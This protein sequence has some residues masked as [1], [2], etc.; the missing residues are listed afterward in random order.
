M[1][2]LGLKT[3]TLIADC[4]GLIERAGR[5]PPDVDHLPLDDPQTY[6][7]FRAAHTAGVFQ[8]ESSG[9]RD[10]LRRL[11]PERFDDLIALNA[12]YRPGPLGA[13]MI[14]DYIQRRHGRVKVAY[15]H[16]LLE[17]ILKPTYGVMVYQEQ[18]MQC[19]SALAGYSLGQADQLRRAMGEILDDEVTDGVAVG[20]VHLLEEVDVRGHHR[21]RA[22]RAQAA[23]PF[24]LGPAEEGPPVERA[25]HGVARRHELELDAQALVGQHDEADRQPE[26]AE[27][28]D[29]EIHLLDQLV[30]EGDV[31]VVDHHRQ[32]HQPPD[33]GDHAEEE[34]DGEEAAA[35]APG[36][37]LPCQQRT[38]GEEAD[39]RQR[40]D[41]NAALVIVGAVGQPGDDDQRR[42]DR[43][44]RRPPVRRPPGIA[45]QADDQQELAEQQQA[46]GG[47]DGDGVRQH[48]AHGG[49]AGGA[50]D[51]EHGAGPVAQAADVVGKAPRLHPEHQRAE[52]AEQIGDEEKAAGIDQ[53]HRVGGGRA[54]Q[55]LL[56]AAFI[57]GFGFRQK[58][59]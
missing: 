8:F 10:I 4:L 7:L 19:A 12:L 30:V 57:G 16:P 11:Q 35:E 15:P 22:V 14:D 13:G 56:P 36:L 3:L 58:V 29:A 18:V 34:E 49:E 17:P 46:A 5:T 42:A 24:D 45:Q 50:R 37:G 40:H 1:D 31:G 28:E 27:R 38:E 53:F 54:R 51:E 47:D 20:V 23:R 41:E 32:R 52:H 25:G 59:A 9:M 44:E 26:H 2:F 48:V 6:D 33:G 55:A 39:V 43:V 21:Q